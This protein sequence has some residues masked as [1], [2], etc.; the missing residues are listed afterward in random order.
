LQSTLQGTVFATRAVQNIEYAVDAA[1]A[2]AFEQ[3]HG[4]VKYFMPDTQA[5]EGSSH[6]APAIQG[7]FALGTVTTHHQTYL[8]KITGQAGFHGR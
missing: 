2:D 8:P 6:S 3:C 5:L 4:A 1:F 7:H